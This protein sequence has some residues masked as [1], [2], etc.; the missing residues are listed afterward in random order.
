[1][2]LFY[3]SRWE[4]CRKAGLVAREFLLKTG[5]LFNQGVT[6]I[7]LIFSLN[8][9]GR[10]A[11]AAEIGREALDVIRRHGERQRNELTILNRVVYVEALTG[12]LDL[13]EALSE[14]AHFRSEMQATGDRLSAN[15]AFTREGRLLALAG[16]IEEAD[17]A[18]ENAVR[19]REDA[20]LTQDYAVWCL[21]VHAAVLLERVRRSGGAEADR[22]SWKKAR[23]AVKQSLAL[24]ANKHPNYRSLALVAGAKLEWLAGKRERAEK[25]FAESYE[26]A[27]RL[28]AKLWLGEA[29][30]EHARC[31]MGAGPA[32]RTAALEHC[33]RAK[34]LITA[35]G[36]S[37]LLPR[38]EEVLAALDPGA[39]KAIA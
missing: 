7:H 24:T 30:L 6:Y 35:C 27:E 3:A 25:S 9:L 20:G 12:S 28:G 4:E 34:K 1:M 19:L 31:L 22:E 32:Q 14:M 33:Q 17:V 39:G 5:G 36:A 15:G 13:T 8:Y 18:L 37:L 26:V 29:H 2:C 23:R 10:L 11:E 21:P 16:R 38:V